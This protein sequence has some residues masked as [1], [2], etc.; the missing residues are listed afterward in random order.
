MARFMA[1][2]LTTRIF[3]LSKV[4]TGVNSYERY[5]H[6][7]AFDLAGEV[8]QPQEKGGLRGKALHYGRVLFDRVRDIAPM[9][10]AL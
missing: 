4:E 5:V 10:I 8:G 6:L 1:V 9:T 7:N 2:L 3:A